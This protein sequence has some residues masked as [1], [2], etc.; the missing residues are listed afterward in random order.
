MNHPAVED[1][2]HARARYEAVFGEEGEGDLDVL[3]GAKDAVEEGGA[4]SGAIW[5]ITGTRGA[6]R[7]SR[8]E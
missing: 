5:R 3:L 7:K 2:A 4:D 8:A 1:A 6:V